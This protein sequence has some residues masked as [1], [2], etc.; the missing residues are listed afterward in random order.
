[1]LEK[2]LPVLVCPVPGFVLRLKKIAGKTKL[3]SS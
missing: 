1:M 2:Y 3:F